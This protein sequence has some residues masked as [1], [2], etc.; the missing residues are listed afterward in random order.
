[1][2]SLSSSHRCATFQQRLIA[3]HGVYLHFHVMLLC[4]ADIAW[5]LSGGTVLSPMSHLVTLQLYWLQLSREFKPLH[6]SCQIRLCGSCLTL[7]MSEF[8]FTNNIQRNSNNAQLCFPEYRELIAPAA[9][10]TPMELLAKVLAL[11]NGNKQRPKNRILKLWPVMG[12]K[13]RKTSS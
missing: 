4:S 7:K 12:A 11:L 13:N 3:W 10:L 2:V 5:R 1:M 6:W 8:W 9:H